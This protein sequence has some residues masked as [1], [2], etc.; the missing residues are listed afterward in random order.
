VGPESCAA[1][2]NGFS[3]HAGLVVPAEP[4]ARLERVC[5][6]V[7]RPP[8]AIDRL[9]L[10]DDGRVR[11]SLRHPWRDGTTDVLFTPIELLERLA[12]L[13]PRS[14]INLILILYFGVLGARAAARAE[15]AGRGGTSPAGQGTTTEA[16]EP[17]VVRGELAES[18]G[19]R[20]RSWAV[21]MQRTF[22]LD[23][24]GCPRCGGRLG[25]SR[26]SSTPRAPLRRTAIHSDQVVVRARVID[27]VQW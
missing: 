16:V 9:H 11:L 15:V 24:L 17:A 10:T 14:R 20:N 8:V 18:G 25:S 4:R 26:S 13:V 3:L 19:G 27:G 6:Y 1:R 12:V 7:L 22:G 23:V 21:L 5:R 2:A